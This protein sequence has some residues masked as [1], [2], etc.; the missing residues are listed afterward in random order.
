MFL[1]FSGVFDSSDADEVKSVSV[2]EGD[3][4]TLNTDV[5][6][7]QRDDL[8]LWMFNINNSD[9]RIAEIHRKNI[10]IDDST[11]IFGDRLQIDSQTGS[12]TIRN[13]RTEHSG[14]YKLTIIKAAVTYKIFSVAVYGN[15][16]CLMKSSK[17]G[18]GK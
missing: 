14:L 13:I 15:I 9:T 7:V 4:V 18:G 5:T 6:E 8:I 10:Y 11:V 17:Q 12:L 3:N 2:T 16:T 1:F